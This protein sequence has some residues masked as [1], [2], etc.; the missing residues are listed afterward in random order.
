MSYEGLFDLTGKRALI[1]GGG[2]LGTEMAMAL[3]QHGARLIIVNLEATAYDR[4]ATVVVTDKLGNF[5]A[6]ALAAF[7]R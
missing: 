6:S 4:A 5:A 2:E 7:T 1:A 3:A